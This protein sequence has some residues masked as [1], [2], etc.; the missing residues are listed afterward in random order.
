MQLSHFLRSK[1]QEVIIS[2]DIYY[3]L[4]KVEFDPLRITQVLDNLISNSL[5]FTPRGGKIVVS[6]SP[7]KES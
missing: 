6:A 3:P 4:P 1:K 7:S 5:K 2:T